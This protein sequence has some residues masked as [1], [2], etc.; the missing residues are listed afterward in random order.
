MSKQQK[1]PAGQGEA[2]GQAHSEASISIP[3]V[4]E[5]NPM[6]NLD[7]NTGE[8]YACDACGRSFTQSEWDDRHDDEDSGEDRY[9]HAECCPICD[10]QVDTSAIIYGEVD[11]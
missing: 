3:I 11:L 6:N 8:G 10:S 4:Q 5:Q 7:P 9:Y 1:S 2:I